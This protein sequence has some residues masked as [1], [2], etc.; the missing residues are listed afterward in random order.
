MR[1]IDNLEELKVEDY[2]FCPKGRNEKFI[3]KIIGLNKKVIQIE[4]V[5][6]CKYD[7]ST[8]E[9][10]RRFISDTQ[11]IIF[12]KVR[13]TRKKKL[14]HKVVTYNNNWIIFKLTEKERVVMIKK[15][16]LENLG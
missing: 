12:K 4:I 9:W 8:N 5:Q 1:L 15:G 6:D 3:Y 13:K 14:K 7:F 11:D 16:I 2:I 10:R